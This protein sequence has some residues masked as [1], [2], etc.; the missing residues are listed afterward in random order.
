MTG[1]RYSVPAIGD[2]SSGE[3]RSTGFTVGILVLLLCS[4]KLSV[5]VSGVK[6]TL[7]LLLRGLFPS[8]ALAREELDPLALVEPE[9]TLVALAPDSESACRLFSGLDTGRL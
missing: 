7:F 4:S 1:C 6:L 5:L 8:L 2:L 3:A 9:L